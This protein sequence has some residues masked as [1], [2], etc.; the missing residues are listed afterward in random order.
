VQFHTGVI[1][2]EMTSLRFQKVELDEVEA[3][4]EHYPEKFTMTISVFVSDEEK[5]PLKPEPWADH[6]TKSLSPD[7]LFST[8]LEK[9]EVMETFGELN[10]NKIQTSKL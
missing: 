4:P 2:E 8:K 10:E 3:S 5:P 9:E 7:L 6:H 1:A